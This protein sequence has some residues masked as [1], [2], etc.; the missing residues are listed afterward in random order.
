MP[1]CNRS[2]SR[3]QIYHT[4]YPSICPSIHLFIHSSIHQLHVSNIPR[5]LYSSA[6]PLLL[7]VS[8]QFPNPP[9]QILTMRFTNTLTATVALAAAPFALGL[10]INCRGS[11][12][13]SY[14][15]CP[16]GLDQ[17]NKILTNAISYGYGNNWYNTG[18]KQP[19]LPPPR[20]WH[21]SSIAKRTPLVVQVA[22]TG[23]CCAFFQNGASGT[24]YNVRDHV[25]RLM[26]HG[27][28]ICGSNPT[29]PGNDVST[30]QLTV[31]YVSNR[32][33]QGNGGLCQ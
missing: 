1:I 29:K 23:N 19:Q 30:G 33:A 22:C 8:A 5:H 12:A 20:Y 32:C 6:Q 25:Q 16:G 17:M 2:L 10:G 7:T 9:L 4:I 24:V 21:W 15:A 31:N 28:K 11:A 13:C 27:C 26:S 14:A 18:G 3:N